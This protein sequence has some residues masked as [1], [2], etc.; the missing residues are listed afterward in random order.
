MTVRYVIRKEATPEQR[1]WRARI[2]SNEKPLLASFLAWV[3]ELRERLDENTL[4]SAIVQRSAA[5]LDHILQA[6][7]WN[8]SLW[9]VAVDEAERAF[10]DL[11]GPREPQLHLSFNLHDPNFDQM[12]R[13]QQARLVRE[14]TAETRRA[15]GNVISR[16]YASNT[17]PYDLV[18]QIRELVG[19]TSRQATAVMNFAEAQ[20][21]NGRSPEVSAD[22]AIRYARKMRTRRA[23]LIAVTE[24]SRAMTA[25]RIASYEQ[26]AASGLFDRATAELEWSAVQTDPKEICAQLDGTRVPLGSTWEGGALP[27]FVHPGCRCSAVL[28]LPTPVVIPPRLALVR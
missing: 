14:V 11:V 8:P 22:R 7:A 10:A 3:A 23:K 25:A 19:L 6:T 28:V 2:A 4:Y 5:S 17:H 15:I 20:R 26:A 12:V 21:K 9:P 1:S 18:P 13:Q 27:G 16:G 24:T